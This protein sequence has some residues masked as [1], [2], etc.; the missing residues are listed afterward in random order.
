MRIPTRM[1]GLISAIAVA[2]LVAGTAAQERA[3]Q[4]PASPAPISGDIVRVDASA[5]LLAVKTADGAEVEFT[6]NDSTEVTGAKDGAAGLANMKSGKVTVHYT[7]VG[8]KKAKT[9][10]K[11]EIQAEKQ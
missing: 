6:Y 10:T 2:L 11:I 9:A 4:N 3:P 8:D 1:V 7:E 5:K